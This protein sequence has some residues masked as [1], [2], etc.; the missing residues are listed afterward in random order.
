MREEPKGRFDVDDSIV[1][2]MSAF[3]APP[4][5][6]AAAQALAHAEP[7]EEEA[8]GIYADN[9]ATVNAFTALRTQWQYAG[10]NGQRT[11]LSYAGVA[12]WL[13]VFRPR[14]RRTLMA[15]LQLMEAAVLQ[16]DQ[17]KREKEE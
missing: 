10:M 8:F 9:V 1:E 2:A 3:G 17:E 11:G 4:Q 14:Q 6:I 12:A 13:D 16:A 7:P 15:D 5:A